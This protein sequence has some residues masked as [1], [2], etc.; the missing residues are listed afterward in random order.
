MRKL[1]LTSAAIIALG[2]G[3]AQAQMQDDNMSE[4]N[5]SEDNMS[6]NGMAMQ[7]D[8]AMTMT[9]AQT[10]TYNG[11]SAEQKTMFD[12]WDMN[13]KRLYFALSP[14]QRTQLWKL[15]P[16]AREA[17]WQQIYKAAGMSPDGT[18]ASDSGNAMASDSGNAMAGE[19]SG[20]MAG[21]NMATGSG[22][23]AN[24][25]AMASPPAAS[26]NKDYPTC[27]RTLTDNCV[28]PGGK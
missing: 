27:S 8:M 16:T 22:T 24:S 14:E 17:A 12:G 26:A 19:R 25:G 3:S 9:P 1:I 15:N 10:A 18:M 5:M 28:N 20:A 11:L 7:D 23:R 4:D 6:D 21:D 13:K 2:A